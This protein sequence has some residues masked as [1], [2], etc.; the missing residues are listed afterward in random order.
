M[1][2]A[3]VEASVPKVIRGHNFP[4]ASLDEVVSTVPAWLEEASEFVRFEEAP[5]VNRLDVVRDFEVGSGPISPSEVIASMSAVPV[6][7]RATKAHY[8]DSSEHQ[9]QTYMVRTKRTGAGRLYDKGRESGVA[10]A[11]GFVR[12]EAQERVQALRRGGVLFFSD[13]LDADTSAL[14]RARFRWCGFDR[15]FS[16]APALLERVWADEEL[17]EGQKLQLSGFYSLRSLGVGVTLERHRHYRMRKLAERFGYPS[18]AG[19]FRLDFD[20]GLVAA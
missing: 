9:A 10:A 7:L 13:L 5:R 8:R 3:W 16:T 4:A 11:E 6:T 14:A 20:H 19:A 15:E 18:D 2:T 12:F 17:T 1:G